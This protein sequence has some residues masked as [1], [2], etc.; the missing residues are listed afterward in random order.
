MT[1]SKTIREFSYY[2]TTSNSLGI[3]VSLYGLWYEAGILQQ[4]N[5]AET[6]SVSKIPASRITIAFCTKN[7]LLLHS[8]EQNA[9]IILPSGCLGIRAQTAV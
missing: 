9:G 1:C 8:D 4:E 7:E 3:V 2:F 5:F 6:C